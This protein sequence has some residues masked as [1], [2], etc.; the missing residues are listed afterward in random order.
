MIVLNRDRVTVKFNGSTLKFNVQIK[1]KN[2]QKKEKIFI[3]SRGTFLIE[4]K[5][6]E[7]HQLLR[8]N[9]FNLF[10]QQCGKHKA[11]GKW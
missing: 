4:R 7:N 9:Q 1:R 5:Y 6:F 8:K 3:T 2:L 11:F 10:L